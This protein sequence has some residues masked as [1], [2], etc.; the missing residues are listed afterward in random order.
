MDNFRKI[1]KPLWYKCGMEAVKYQEVLAPSMNGDKGD[2]WNRRY[3][4]GDYKGD[5]KNYRFWYSWPYSNDLDE[6]NEALEIYYEA[7]EGVWYVA[8]FI[9]L[10]YL[11][12]IFKKNKETGECASG[13]WFAMQDNMVVLERLSK[14]NIK[15]TIDDLIENSEMDH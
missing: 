14:E 2:N 7:K 3:I 12:S 13:T 4:E 11:K 8:N 6:E 1:Y 10:K 15:I 5:F 9:T